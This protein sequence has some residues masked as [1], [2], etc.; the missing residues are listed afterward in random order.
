[1]K[2]RLIANPA[3][4]KGKGVRLID[5]ALSSLSRHGITPQISITTHP[6]HARSL[7]EDALGSFEAIAGLGGD[8]TMNEIASAIKHTGRPLAV[9]PAG[10]GNDFIKCLGNGI[11]YDSVSGALAQMNTSY[12]DM[13]MVNGRDMINILGIGFDAIVAE[14]NSR[15]KGMGGMA[16]YAWALLRSLGKFRHYPLELHINGE[17][18]RANALFLSIGNG[19]VCGGGFRLTPG[20]LPDDGLLDVTLI[21][22]L[23]LRAVPLHIHKAFNGKIAGTPYTRTFRAQRLSISSTS[24]LPSHIDGEVLEPYVDRYDIEVLPGALSVVRP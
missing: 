18:I 19:P 3:S 8:G 10:T 1:M 16:S 22:D 4:A 6:G 9:Y 23:P 15:I 20:A 5:R 17:D 21:S 11:T 13:A 7:A 14:K 2:V 12:I 24:P